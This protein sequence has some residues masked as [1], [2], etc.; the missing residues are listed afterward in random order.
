MKKTVLIIF[1]ILLCFN[2]RSQEKKDFETKNGK[3]YFV[4]LSYTYLNVDLK[5]AALSLH[6]YW[7]GED[8]G[9]HVLTDAEIN[10]INDV[11]DRNMKINNVNLEAGM[12]FLDNPDSKWHFNGKLFFGLAGSESETQN[13][14]TDSLEYSF[15]TRFTKPCTGLGFDVGYSF[16]QH[17]GLSIRPMIM[18]TIGKI[19]H[20]ID[21][22]NITPVNVTET[23]EDQYFSLY[24]HMSLTADFTAGHFTISAGPGFYWI[25]SRHKYTINRV[26]DLNGDI[27]IDDITSKTITRTFIDGSIA[28]EWRVIEPLTVYASAGISN[29]LLINTGIHFNF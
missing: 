26:N 4:G 29:D 13:T 8:L 21:N 3:R 19:T 16:D 23:R 27:M 2:A 7:Y 18:G 28:V 11:I 12:A 6:S 15:D 14:A 25:N 10:E 17:W 22:V 9:T 1:V 5:L 24:E 20:I